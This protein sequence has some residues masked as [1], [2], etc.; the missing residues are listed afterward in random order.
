M[1]AW[2]IIRTLGIVV[3]QGDI[4]D[5]EDRYLGI[6]QANGNYKEATRKATTAKHLH[7]VKQEQ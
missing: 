7:K 2:M 4:T 5:V 1:H 6:P 3:L